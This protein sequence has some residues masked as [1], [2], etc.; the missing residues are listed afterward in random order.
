MILTVPLFIYVDDIRDHVN[1]FIIIFRNRSISL[2]INTRYKICEAY[3]VAN[4]S[5]VGSFIQFCQHN[6]FVLCK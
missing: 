1:N 2:S 3:I 4:K 5:N 6:V